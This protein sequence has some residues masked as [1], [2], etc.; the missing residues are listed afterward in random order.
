M[1]LK[2]HAAPQFFRSLDPPREGAPRRAPAVSRFAA[3]ARIGETSSFECSQP[4]PG[5]RFLAGSRRPCQNGAGQPRNGVRE[6]LGWVEP[7]HTES[8]RT[9]VR[10]NPPI[11][12]ATLPMFHPAC[13]PAGQKRH[14][15]AHATPK[16]PSRAAS[17][18]TVARARF[19]WDFL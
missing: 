8:P 10:R 15:Q 12:G 14:S 17:H 19:R 6:G 18:Q 4:R 9:M 1:A 3:R 16:R 5:A 11:L 13:R 2:H 7:S